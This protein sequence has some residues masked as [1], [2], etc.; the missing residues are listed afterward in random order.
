MKRAS[1]QIRCG[2]TLIELL[3]VIAIIGTLIG[4]L[5]PAVQKVREAAKRSQCQNNLHQIMLSTNLHVDTKGRLPPMGAPGRNNI[6]GLNS[7]FP[8]ARPASGYYDGKGTASSEAFAPSPCGHLSTL[9]PAPITYEAPIWYHLLPYIEEAAI[10]D[11]TPPAFVYGTSGNNYANILL[12]FYNSD[13]FPNGTPLADMLAD[14]NAAQTKVPPFICPSESNVP[15]DGLVHLGEADLSGTAYSTKIYAV[16]K[17]S[18]LPNIP[19]PPCANNATPMVPTELTGQ[20]LPW[21]GNDYAANYLVFGALATAR[22]PDTIPDGTSKTIFFTEK[23][24]V[25]RG[26][27]QLATGSVNWNGIGGNLWAFPPFFPLTPASATVPLY[28][29]AGEV[30]FNAYDVQHRYLALPGGTTAG[31]QTLYANALSFQPNSSVGAGDPLLPQTPH[32]GGINVAMGDGSVKFVSSSIS[33]QTWRAA[34]T[35]RPVLGDTR[36]DS[37]G[38]DWPD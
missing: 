9:G 35:P 10:Y 4:M 28:N 1:R 32:T 6:I 17:C 26:P 19:C 12:L 27:I 20:S 38:S 25:C 14:E 18:G 23:I 21:G 7:T 15:S 22:F 33:P 37:L 29:Y 13:R 5:L 30:G 31:S 11:R 36:G 34:M 16:D 2:F 24:A 3:V 8:N